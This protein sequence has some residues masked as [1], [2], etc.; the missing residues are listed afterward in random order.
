MDYW[1]ALKEL[2]AEKAK[3]DE[4]ISTLETLAAANEFFPRRRGRKPMALEEQN[5]VYEKMRTYFESRRNGA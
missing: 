4:A 3:L 5:R 1:K 2:S